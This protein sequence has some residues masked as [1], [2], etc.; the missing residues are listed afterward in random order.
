MEYRKPVDVGLI[1]SQTPRGPRRDIAAVLGLST[2][3]VH[4]MTPDVGGAFGARASV[5]PEELALVLLARHLESLGPSIALR[6]RSTRS[7]DFVAGPHGRGSRLQG[8]LWVD[9]QGSV[10]GL[11]A[12]L[13]FTLGAWLPYSSMVPLRN[14]V[15]ILP[16]PYTL[17]QID[18][19]GVATRSHAA[20]VG[21]YRGWP[22]R[23]GHSDG[24]PH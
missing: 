5:S 21:I 3:R 14:A 23:G 13:H 18:L 4:V 9:P 7:E 8:A 20:P 10:L 6:W 1:G 12:Q 24:D 15:R 19:Q 16:G 2:D 11:R 22:A 17:Q